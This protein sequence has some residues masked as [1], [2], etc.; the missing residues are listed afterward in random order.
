MFNQ[1]KL[2]I[3]SVFLLFSLI[4]EVTSSNL[5]RDQAEDSHLFDFSKYP[6]EHF[7]YDAS[8]KKEMVS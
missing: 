8:R 1:L 4:Y 6:K 2:K 3:F 5:Y 7:A